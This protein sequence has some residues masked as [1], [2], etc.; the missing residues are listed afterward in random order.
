MLGQSLS[1]EAGLLTGWTAFLSPSHQCRGT[2]E[3]FLIC[4]Y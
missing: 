2:K 4:C 1:V 3:V